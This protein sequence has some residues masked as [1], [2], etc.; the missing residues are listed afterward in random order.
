MGE[1]FRR[2]NVGAGSGDRKTGDQESLEPQRHAVMSQIQYFMLPLVFDCGYRGVDVHLYTQPSKYAAELQSWY[3]AFDSETVSNLGATELGNVW[4]SFE[5]P[6]L[7]ESFF[8]GWEYDGVMIGRPDLLVKPYFVPTFLAANRSKFLS[9]FKLE[10]HPNK[11]G[12][13]DDMMVG[14]TGILANA[15]SW[16]WLPGWSLPLVKFD[17]KILL[18]HHDAFVLWQPIVGK[19]NM[20]YLLPDDHCNANPFWE[21]NSIYSFAGR[22]EGGVN[23]LNSHANKTYEYRGQKL[24]PDCL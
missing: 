8:M 18:T 14:E 7:A 1:S 23:P 22:A 2:N 17:P 6:A 10:K 20:D 16:A 19:E 12:V 11:L 9:N 4:N 3:D 21:C 15:G 13:L 24:V 5:K